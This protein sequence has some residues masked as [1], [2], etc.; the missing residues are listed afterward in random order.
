MPLTQ[1]YAK[2]RQ[3]EEYRRK[4]DLKWQ[5]KYIKRGVQN[6][7]Y[8]QE[9]TTIQENSPRF[10]KQLRAEIDQLDSNIEKQL[11]GELDQVNHR[12]LKLEL[13]KQIK[14]L[15]T[16]IGLEKR[17]KG[18]PAEVAKKNQNTREDES[19]Q[20][21]TISVTDLDLMPLDANSFQIQNLLFDFCG[22]GNHQR[23]IYKDK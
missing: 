18:D 22:V 6:N 1:I 12:Q 15:K 3:N 19:V 21:Q 5:R 9:E 20:K 7:N 11:A 23:K 10:E 17:I 2:L 16:M 13:E 4:R 14:Q 8:R